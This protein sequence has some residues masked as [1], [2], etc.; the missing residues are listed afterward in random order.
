M[1]YYKNGNADT[2]RQY[3]SKLIDKYPSTTWADN[4]RELIKEM[5]GH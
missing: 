3:L 5:N 4:A 2:A 1:C